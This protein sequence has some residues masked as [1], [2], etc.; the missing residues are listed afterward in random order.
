MHSYI[1][2]CICTCI[3]VSAHLYDVS[4]AGFYLHPFFPTHDNFGCT[5]TTYALRAATLYMHTYTYT[6]MCTCIH[7]YAH[8]YGV[9]VAGFHL[10]SFLPILHATM[11]SRHFYGVAPREKTTP[12]CW[13][14]PKHPSSATIPSRWTEYFL[15]FPRCPPISVS[16]VVVVVVVVDDELGK[17]RAGNENQTRIVGGVGPFASHAARSRSLCSRWLETK[18]VKLHPHVETWTFQRVYKVPSERA[19]TLRI[20]RFS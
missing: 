3:Q 15:R 4:V 7:V 20:S 18:L 6:C 10:R 13:R 1:Y 16:V 19:R 17:F 14:I 2:T 11:A 8:L 5:Q 9:S 12:L